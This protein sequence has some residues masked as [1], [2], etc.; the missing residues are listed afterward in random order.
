MAHPQ[1]LSSAQQ[2]V[3]QAIVSF[4]QSH[5]ISPTYKELADILGVRSP[6]GVFQIV[7]RLQ[8]KGWVSI[9]PGLSRSL[10]VIHQAPCINEAD[11]T[12]VPVLSES[13][14]MLGEIKVA[15]MVFNDQPDEIV[16]VSA[17]KFGFNGAKEGDLV[18]VKRSEGQYA[19]IGLIRGAVI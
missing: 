12:R 10:T 19:Q 6:N 7:E 1:A 18:A 11:D 13:G 3:Y 9:K 14:E 15:R 4:I 17:N 5:S 8:S 2:K 16:R